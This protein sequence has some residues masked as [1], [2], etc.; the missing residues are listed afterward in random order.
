MELAA[1][2][3]HPRNSASTHS[4]GNKIFFRPS[5]GNLALNQLG[6]EAKTE[7]NLRDFS[8]TRGIRNTHLTDK[9]EGGREEE[10]EG[11]SASVQDNNRAVA[12][13]VS[14]DRTCSSFTRAKNAAL[15]SK[16]RHLSSIEREKGEGI[17]HSFLGSVT[18]LVSIYE[19]VVSEG[20]FCG[21]EMKNLSLATTWES[22]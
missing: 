22:V 20:K 8:G 6:E 15:C 19:A 17:L 16:A 2:S 10:G 11:S 4:I 1:T 3:P 13:R 9:S 14:S 18:A 5:R 21:F 12:S 7:Q